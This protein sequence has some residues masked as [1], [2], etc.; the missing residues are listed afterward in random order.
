MNIDVVNLGRM[1]YKQAL[2]IQEQ[3]W[4]RVSGGNGSDTLLLVEHPPVLTLGLRG[5]RENILATDELLSEKGVSVYP[6]GR[7]GDVTYHGPGQI[8]GYPIFN[9][10]HWGKDIHAFVMKLEDVFI[11]L[12][13][14]GF[15]IGAHRQEKTYTGVFVGNDKITA[16]GI[17]V[18]KWTT[19][20]GFAFNVNT[21]L[22]HFQWI[23][24]CGLTDRGVTSVERLTGKKQD[25]NDMIH[26]VAHKLCN[27]FDATPIFKDSEDMEWK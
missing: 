9:L 15:G 24:P 7:G 17:Q 21:D 26:A 11:S 16:I 3:Q 6:V 18:K 1:D 20:H 22:S 23:V 10:N 4:E 8:V 25:M 12:L 19:L 14:E 2:S 13:K 5:K 27:N